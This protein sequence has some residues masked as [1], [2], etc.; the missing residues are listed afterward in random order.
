M[1]GLKK[2]RRGSG[3]WRETWGG[4]WRWPSWFV[5]PLRDIT[6]TMNAWAAAGIPMAL[7]CGKD[8]DHITEGGMTP[9]IA[10]EQEL[11]KNMDSWTPN[12]FVCWPTKMS[13]QSSFILE[14]VSPLQSLPTKVWFFWQEAAYKSQF[15]LIVGIQW[16]FCS[17]KIFDKQIHFLTWWPLKHGQNSQW[18]QLPRLHCF[19]QWE[20]NEEST[21]SGGGN[22]ATKV[23]CGDE[24]QE[25]SIR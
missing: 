4:S 7:W 14:Q 3:K 9:I 19:W 6:C 20:V 11:I 10:Q 22:M 15:F 2:G 25:C 24:D 21:N 1:K 8:K 12:K 23:V 5:Q 18:Q 13:Q 17:C 16:Q